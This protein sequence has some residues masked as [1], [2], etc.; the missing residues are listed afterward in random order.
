MPLRVEKA[1]AVKYGVEKCTTTC[2]VERV[3][4]GQPKTAL[5]T[6]LC[7][8][9]PPSVAHAAFRKE[10]IPR[11]SRRSRDHFATPSRS[12][13]MLQTLQIRKLAFSHRALASWKK[14]L[15]GS[16]RAWI[17]LSY[18]RLSNWGWVTIEGM[19]G[20]Y[21]DVDLRR[22]PSA[23]WR[24][25]SN[26]LGLCISEI[27]NDFRVV[28]GE[29]LDRKSQVLVL[30]QFSLTISDKGRSQVGSELQNDGDVDAGTSS[31][32]V[33]LCDTNV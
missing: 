12:N 18:E 19:C 24:I 25:L 14:G 3:I 23:H 29:L 26:Q 13:T 27:I 4:S 32:V 8:A 10:P 33:R 5:G 11:T 15:P 6:F 28:L 1:S 30:A 21:S 31:S 7:A 2:V 9:G 17:G 16:M 20:G 22:K